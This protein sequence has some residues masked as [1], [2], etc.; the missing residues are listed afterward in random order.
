MSINSTLNVSLNQ[1]HHCRHH[2]REHLVRHRCPYQ[3][4]HR[5]RDPCCLQC[6]HRRHRYRGHRRYRRHRSRF[7]D[8]P[9]FH[10]CRHHCQEHQVCLLYKFTSTKEPLWDCYFLAGGEMLPHLP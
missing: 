7:R 1:Y 4:P 8:C 10:R 3:R 6:R 5:R 9:G 2:C